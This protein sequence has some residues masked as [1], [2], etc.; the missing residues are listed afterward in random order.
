MNP[1]LIQVETV[2][3]KKWCIHYNYSTYYNEEITDLCEAAIRL[4]ENNFCPV[5]YCDDLLF[6][7][8]KNGKATVE[9]L[10]I[11]QSN[12]SSEANI[13]FP[14]SLANN[15][16]PFDLEGA[17]QAGLYTYFENQAFDR[18][19]AWQ[20]PYIRAILYPYRFRIENFNC[21]LYP[22][23]KIFSDGAIIVS[24]CILSPDIEL[25]I[26]HFINDF[27]NLFNK[28]VSDIEIPPE[29]LSLEAENILLTENGGIR[30]RIKNISLVKLLKKYIK[31][32]SYSTKSGDFDYSFTSMSDFKKITNKEYGMNSIKDQVL[33]S[34]CTAL[35]PRINEWRYI[36]AGP[37]KLLYSS[38]FWMGRPSICIIDYTGIPKTAGQIEKKYKVELGKIL[39]RSTLV[40][41]NSAI[42][43]IKNN[44]RCFD[45]VSIQFNSAL[46]LYIYSQAGINN[47]R[48]PVENYFDMIMP[49]QIKSEYIDYVL[50]TYRKIEAIST[51]PSAT[52]SDILK[53]RK[54]LSLIDRMID[55]QSYSHYGDVRK[56]I[57][58]SLDMLQLDRLRSTIE[59]NIAIKSQTLEILSN[60][61]NRGF[62]S[63]ITIVFGIVG[64]SG[65]SKDVVEQFFIGQSD[66]FLLPVSLI[67]FVFTAA[68]MIL[69]VILVHEAMQIL[70]REGT[71]KTKEL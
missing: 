18:D 21:E 50:I 27:V 26:E 51:D 3:L 55:L 58:Q 53:L 63:L 65:L 20:S 31:A 13:R 61:R 42:E 19:C 69:V 59:K 33:V 6:F 48:Y 64:A 37:P 12:Y 45:D 56:Y 28:K 25:E 11:K 34:L 7:K 15:N 38:G 36:L 16:R 32:K 23:V 4:I 24:F 62:V 47:R 57:D 29:L 22:S 10:I 41:E 71:S 8:D 70:G 52:I 39:S 14:E 2:R 46:Q 68:L 54:K 60:R 66:Y 5:C 40:N 44:I 1:Y 35:N 43:H 49:W 30:N 9:P 67:S 17:F